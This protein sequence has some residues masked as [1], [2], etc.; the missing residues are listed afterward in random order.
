MRENKNSKLLSA[1]LAILMI[2][3]MLPVTTFAEEEMILQEDPNQIVE[4]NQVEEIPEEEILEEVEEAPEEQTEELIV[5][6]KQ[7]E[8]IIEVVESPQPVVENLEEFN[9]L[10]EV[11]ETIEEPSGIEEVEQ[12]NSLEEHVEEV[13]EEIQVEETSISNEVPVVKEVKHDSVTI[14]SV[15]ENNEEL[16]GTE[17]AVYSDIENLETSIIKTISAATFTLSTIDEDLKDFLPVEGSTTLYLKETKV[18]EGYIA[19]TEIYTITIQIEVDEENN[20]IVYGLA[21]DDGQKELRIIHEPVIETTSEEEIEVVEEVVVLGATAFRT[22]PYNL[23]PEEGKILIPFRKDWSGSGDTE[24]TRPS[25]ITISLY[26]YLGASFDATTATLVDTKLVTAAEGWACEFDISKENL[27][28]GSVYNSDSAYKWAVVESEVIGYKETGHVNPSVEFN[29]PEVAGNGWDRTTPCS[30]ISITSSGHDKSVVCAKKG[31]TYVIWSVDP[32]SSAERELIFKSAAAG[33]KGFGS[34]NINNCTFISGFGSS[35]EFGMTVTENSIQFNDTSNWSFYA[36]GIYNKSSTFT[37]ASSITN[38]YLPKATT[39]TLPVTKTIEGTPHS[40]ANFDFVLTTLT[41]NAP[42]PVSGG[43]KLTITGEGTGNFGT[44]T[45]TMPGTWKYSVYEKAGSLEAYGYDDNIYKVTVT[46]NDVG[47]EL[48]ALVAI[49]DRSGAS[50]DKMEFNNLYLTGDLIV[51]KIIAGNAASIN[52]EYNFKV[53]LSDTSINGLYGDMT[54]VNGVA[55]F[56]LKGG[57]RVFAKNLPAGVKYT[58]TEDDYSSEGYITTQTNDT[59]VIT[60]N[61]EIQATFTNT[62]NADGSLTILKKLAGNDPNPE[63][64]FKFTIELTGKPVNGNYSGVIFTDN[65]ATLELKG[66]ESKTIEGLPVGTIYSVEEYDYKSEGY[67]TSATNNSNSG[68]IKEHTVA[69]AE[70]INTRNTYGDLIIKKKVGG[71]AADTNKAFNFTVTLSDTNINGAYGDLTFKDGVATFELKDGERK[72]AKNLPNGVSYK[73]EEDNYTGLGYETMITGEEGTITGGNEVQA[74]FINYRDAYG[75]LIIKK[76]LAGNDINPD[77]E[78]TFY[79]N[80]NDDSINTTFGGIEFIS[81]QATVDIKGNE[82]L[83]INGIPHGTNYTVTERNYRREGYETTSINE[84]G[85]INE[86]SPAITEFTNTRNTY[87]DLIV[88]KR[89]AGNAANRDQRFLF[90]VTLSDTTI[91]DKFGDM[92]FENG[93]AKFELSGGESKK[94]VNLPNGITYKVVED[95][96]SSLGYVTTKTHDTGTITGN[97]EVE[98]IFTNT[99]DTYGSLEVSKVLT[100]NDVD[101]NK[102][103][104]FTIKLTGETI[105]GTYSGVTFTNNTATIKLKG[106][107]YKFIEGLPNGIR[108]DV[109]EDN[110]YADGYFTSRTGATGTIVENE[111]MIAEFVN[112]RNTYGS[113]IVEKKLEGNAPHVN[114]SFSFTVTLSDTNIS[115]KYGDMVFENGIAKFELKGGEKLQATGLPNGLTYTVSEKDYTDE[116]Y[117]TTKYNDTGTIVGN[118]EITVTFV[119]ERNATGS[120]IISKKLDG[121]D[122]NPEDKFKFTIELTG[123]PVNGNYSGVIFTDNKAT[124]ELKGG[125]SKQIDGLPNGITY[126][127]LEDSYREQGYFTM[128]TDSFTGQI[129]EN[130]PAEVVYI[131]I[132]DT[133]GDLTVKKV[134]AGNATDANK[135]FNF[136]VILSDTSITDGYGSMKFIE[137]KATFTLKG[138]EEIKATGLP[139]G[140]TYTVIEDDYSTQGYKTTKTNDTGKIVGNSEKVVTFTNT[141]NETPKPPKPQQNDKPLPQYGSLIITKRV[142]GDLAEY[143]KYFS[144]KV[145]FN[146]DGSYYY[147]GVRTGNLKSGDVIQLKHDESITIYGLPDG[148][149]YTVTEIGNN[150]YRVYASGNSG[151]ISAINIATASFTNVRSKAPITGDITNLPL[152]LG[153]SILSGLGLLF[154][155]FYRRKRNK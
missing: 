113:L 107:E 19:D 40:S 135:A 42:M 103:F 120:L 99:R 43:E 64:K 20:T 56:T 60:Y 32:L 72:I 12:I 126:T 26:K 133:F 52:K 59:G 1:L 118:K 140:V 124:L 115:N 3:S 47:G 125:E 129:D 17:F 23:N 33:I 90:T 117:I 153:S 11:E 134:L 109:S 111:K 89:L 71:N 50:V 149:K 5:E 27:Y 106:G 130:K 96:Y 123:K 91:S 69:I 122:P 46:V 28:S 132:R 114:K 4:E 154:I 152:W 97:E 38:T 68:I 15:N 145:T 147:D 41:E 127:V 98:A 54:F 13:K 81:G 93:V 131:N 22:L 44:I 141:R 77:D 144:F 139:N 87:G 94:A 112:S 18:P 6:E 78:F 63:D 146:V 45:Y 83:T 79:I 51:Q 92:V 86:H 2:F 95:D 88:H 143:D 110:Y 142:T 61:N 66:G 121:N 31:S 25:S 7:I 74:L 57:E 37:N 39:V 34:G 21:F 80:L 24:A 73:V 16:I 148:T 101:T 30:E 49:E 155:V 136:T 100:G 116:G 137:G 119:N 151:T 138:G 35:S 58:V 55:E 10:E 108:Y 9:P 65:K 104:N 48:V 75:S 53:T 150:G 67:E 8:E 70:F 102:E 62:R 82:S 85:T 14:L 36:L 128:T 84:E 105:N 76:H 29:P